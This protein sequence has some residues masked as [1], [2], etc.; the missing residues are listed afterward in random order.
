MSHLSKNGTAKRTG[1]CL[2][3]LKSASCGI[4]RQLSPTLPALK[5]AVSKYHPDVR[6][7][8]VDV[9]GFLDNG[10]WPAGLAT[11]GTAVPRFLLIAGPVWN[12]AKA[13][14]KLDRAENPRWGKLAA[15][16]SG[17]TGSVFTFPPV[18]GKVDIS[19]GMQMANAAY[20]KD[21]KIYEPVRPAINVLNVDAMVEWL[22]RAKT[23]PDFIAAQGG[24]ST[25]NGPT[26]AAAATGAIPPGV[27]ATSPPAGKVTPT[28]IQPNMWTA[29]PPAKLAVTPANPTALLAPTSYSSSTAAAPTQAQS[30]SAVR[31]TPSPGHP[32]VVPASVPGT[33]GRTA[34][35]NVS[36]TTY[37]NAPV[38]T[39]AYAS[40]TA[41]TPPTSDY[42]NTITR[43]PVVGAL[44]NNRTGVTIGQVTSLP[45]PPTRSTI[46]VN[47]A[48]FAPD[49]NKMA[50]CSGHVT[51]RATPYSPN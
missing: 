6:I 38:A 18:H 33:A 16:R 35:T 14:T 47:T 8:I 39:P 28:T 26:P 20:N 49:T 45:P 19:P 15:E 17:G 30:A 51:L 41:Y 22:T 13:G 31:V 3:I 21:K 36:L 34:T 29:P 1:P 5:A 7:K 9:N 48:V 43:G 24:S 4:C 25:T 2:V 11:Y 42:T 23:N 50:R 12:R 37:A 27:P 10:K 40:A 32:A 46:T 44:Q